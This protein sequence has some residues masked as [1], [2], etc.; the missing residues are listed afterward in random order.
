MR[1]TLIAMGVLGGIIAAAANFPLSWAVQM[2]GPSALQDDLR[3]GGTLWNGYLFH[4]DMM[5][6]GPALRVRA[7]PLTLLTGGAFINFDMVNRDVSVNGKLGFNHAKDVVF[8]APISAFAAQDPRFSALSGQ[9]FIALDS[10]DFDSVCKAASGTART[11]VLAANRA[12][13]DWTGPELSGPVSCDGGAVLMTLSGE[14][15]ADLVEA[16]LHLYP[17]GGYALEGRI[18]TSDRRAGAVLPLYGFEK[19]DNGFLINER[20]QWTP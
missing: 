7:S 3:H 14:G 2:L 1:K 9:I 19:K 6:T 16:R 8:S 10:L 13:F 4:A 12:Q 11:T 18:V 5:G 15:N 20:G 17:D